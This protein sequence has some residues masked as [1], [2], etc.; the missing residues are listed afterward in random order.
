MNNISRQ[1]T[2]SQRSALSFF[3]MTAIGGYVTLF[4]IDKANDAI[5]ELTVLSETPYFQL[6]RE[7]EK[8]LSGAEERKETR[9]YS[10]SVFH[11]AFSYPVQWQ[12]EEI[13][14]KKKIVFH[15]PLFQQKKFVNNVASMEI[16][17]DMTRDEAIQKA[18]FVEK[19]GL[20]FVIS[21]FGEKGDPAT[22]YIRNGNNVLI[23]DS[24]VAIYTL[25]GE[26]AGT[27]RNYRVLISRDNRH[28]IINALGSRE[29]L[30]KIIF[31][32][33]FIN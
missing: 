32:F 30:D 24:A 1:F 14:K 33:L 2:R 17:E 23:G 7:L 13:P 25:T 18:F 9:T 12:L 10:N 27:L 31:S 5:D 21:R 26:Y 22:D 28:A 29:T 20:Y 16:L 15:D 4:L 11:V 3:V 6:L 8:E 19:N